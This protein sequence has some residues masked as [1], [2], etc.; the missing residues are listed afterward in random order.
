MSSKHAR[1]MT[2]EHRMVTS[3][4]PEIDV[5]EHRPITWCP[6]NMPGSWPVSTEWWCHPVLRWGSVNTDQWQVFKTCQDHD[7]WARNGDITQSRDWCQWTQAS[8]MMSSKHARIMTSEHGMVTSPSPETDISEHRPMTWCPQNMPGSWLVSTEWW[9]HPVQKLV[10]VNTDQWHD[11]LKTCQDH[12]QWARNGDITQPRDWCQWTQTNDMMSSKHARIM[13]SEHRMVMSHRGQRA[14]TNDMMSSKHARI[15]T[16]ERKMVTSSRSVNTDQ[17]HHT[18]LKTCLQHDQWTQTNDICHYPENMPWSWSV[19]TDQ[20][21]NT[22]LKTCLQHDQW[23]QTNSITLS[24]KHAFSMISEHRPMTSHYPENMPSA[25]SVNTDQRHHI[26]LKTCLQHDQWTQTNGITL[27][28]KHA[29]SMI[30]EHRPTTSHWLSWKHALS[31]ISEHRPVTSHYPKK[32]ALSMIC[33]H[34][35]VTYAILHKATK[36]SVEE[37]H[38]QERQQLLES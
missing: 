22:I 34:W 13:T 20:R 31:M 38:Y 10:S 18:I 35:P 14:H 15:M 30:S 27:S 25:W 24:W 19:N 17:R 5:S 28:W 36:Q 23:T 8:D 16:C 1:I 2:S 33:E 3:P 11:V 32:N 21:H 4:N 37:E 29:F 7:Q 12:D 9:H 6:Q 26:I